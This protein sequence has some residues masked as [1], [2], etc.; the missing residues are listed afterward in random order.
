MEFS[1]ELN[2]IAAAL[3]KAQGSMKAAIKKTVNESFG[4]RY[5]D[6]TACLNAALPALTDNGIA[7]CQSPGLPEEQAE[8]AGYGVMIH[9]LLL[10]SSGQWV[11]GSFF[12]PCAN[13]YDAQA[14][15]SAITYGKRYALAA[16]VGLPTVDDDGNAAMPANDHLPQGLT[17]EAFETA[18]AALRLD[19]T[20]AENAG[21]RVS[22]D[23]ATL[24]FRPSFDKSGEL[25]TRQF[26]K[27]LAQ[28]AGI[29]GT[30]WDGKLAAEVHGIGTKAGCYVFPLALPTAEAKTA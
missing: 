11:K 21:F 15:G 7:I 23:G 27:K 16:M 24:Y 4:S 6:L 26:T 25:E 22:K 19:H 1:E 10:H 14:I 20:K 8:G 5:A 28:T 13:R 29:S 2:Q 3:A 18:L 12:M 17:L 9:T 30:G